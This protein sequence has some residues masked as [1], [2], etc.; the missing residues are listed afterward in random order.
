MPAEKHPIRGRNSILTAG[1]PGFSEVQHGTVVFG[2]EGVGLPADAAR[3]R[4]WAGGWH[5]LAPSER[6][7]V[8]GSV[9]GF[10][11]G[12]VAIAMTGRLPSL[13][14]WF[15]LIDAAVFTANLRLQTANAGWHLRINEARTGPPNRLPFDLI[16]GLKCLV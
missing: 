15:A 11:A 3:T 2:G 6:A 4:A 7:M 14:A 13:L 5:A 8:T 16:I 12:I 1:M 10:V 9:C